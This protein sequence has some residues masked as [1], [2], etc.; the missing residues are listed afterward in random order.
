AA[1]M[2]RAAELVRDL[3]GIEASR[4]FTRIWL[5][6]F[7]A[8]PWERLPAL[9]PEVILL[10]SWFPLN[11][12]DF[13]SWARQTIVP[14]CVVAAHRPVRPLGVDLAPLRTGRWE[15]GRPSLRTWSGRFHAL[16]RLLHGYERRPIGPLRRHALALCAEWILRRQEAD[17]CW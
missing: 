13:A 16:D 11:I 5:A 3:G 15:P 1:P 12:Y 17:G 2:R 14:L 9:P 8:W 7:G 6:L 10:P 4:V